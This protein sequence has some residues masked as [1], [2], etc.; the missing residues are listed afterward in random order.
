MP[1]H[2]TLRLKLRDC[3][4]FFRDFLIDLSDGLMEA[5]PRFF[6]GAYD[7]VDLVFHFARIEPLT[8]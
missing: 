6:Q 5:L 3:R 8:R 1:F 2:Q 4:D 7:G